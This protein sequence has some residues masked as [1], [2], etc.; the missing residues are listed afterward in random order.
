MTIKSILAAAALGAVSLGGSAQATTLIGQEVTCTISGQ[1]GACTPSPFTVT[2]GAPTPD[3]QVFLSDGSAVLDI[4]FMDSWVDITYNA[5]TITGLSFGS[6]ALLTLSGLLPASGAETNLYGLSIT[7]IP[8]LTA[9]DF[10]L[11]GGVL[12]IDLSGSSWNS[13]S[14]VG[15]DVAVPLPA[16]A[17][18][19]LGGLAGLGLAARRR[20]PA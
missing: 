10:A 12:T 9:D 14:S 5:G 17:L 18:L 1:V 6:P 11:A 7:N 16:S 2:A 19:L 20:R 3:A 8:G 13:S 4:D 15:F